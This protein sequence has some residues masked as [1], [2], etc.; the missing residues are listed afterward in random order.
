MKAGQQLGASPLSQP[1]CHLPLPV[2]TA[3]SSFGG[4][5]GFFT[6]KAALIQPIL[7][8]LSGVT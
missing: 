6:L 5:L 3:P 2:I 7:H 4:D 8:F 1:C